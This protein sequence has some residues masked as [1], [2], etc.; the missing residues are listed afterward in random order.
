MP[1]A[2]TVNIPGTE[3]NTYLLAKVFNRGNSPT[4][5]LNFGFCE[6]GGWFA[7]IRSKA[8][9]TAIVPCPHM[10]GSAPIIPCTLQPGEIWTGMAA[11]DHE[12]E[13][14]RRARSGK[15]FVVIYASHSDKPL[16]QRVHLAPQPPKDAQEI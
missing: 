3:G 13:L 14:V 8:D 11:H 7:R 12:G 15:L 4:T 2:Q 16:F 5:I 10:P 9:W 1:E 6:F